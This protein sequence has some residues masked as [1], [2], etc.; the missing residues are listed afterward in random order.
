MDLTK[1]L[2]A[3]ALPGNN[4]IVIERL[5]GLVR[6]ESGD[7]TQ[8]YQLTVTNNEVALKPMKN[9]KNRLE[10]QDYGFLA[11]GRNLADNS[12]AVLREV[13]MTCRSQLRAKQVVRVVADMKP[14]EIEAI[15]TKNC[16]EQLPEGWYFDGRMYM[17]YE[18]EYKTEHPNLQLLLTQYL[19]QENLV[20]GD[21]N[22]SVMKD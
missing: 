11:Y 3:S 2:V 19:E 7:T 13:L 12:E 10:E 1:R 16:G 22:R 20:V 8:D 4:N 15:Q 14:E 18:G 9:Q 21:H 17:N 5:R 6:L